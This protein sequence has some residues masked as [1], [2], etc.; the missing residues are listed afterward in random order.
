[1][2]A[3]FEH[4]EAVREFIDRL[5]L[6]RSSHPR[7]RPPPV[8][9]PA[10]EY[11]PQPDDAAA[12]APVLPDPNQIAAPVPAQLPPVLAAGSY[13]VTG[14][15]NRTQGLDQD[16]GTPTS[17]ERSSR[18]RKSSA[19][20]T[21]PVKGRKEVTC[22]EWCDTMERYLRLN[23]VPE[24][25]QVTFVETYLR[26]GALSLSTLALQQAPP[27]ETGSNVDPLNLRPMIKNWRWLRDWLIS[28]FQPLNTHQSVRDELDV[29]ARRPVSGSV[30]AGFPP[31]V[32]RLPTMSKEERLHHPP[33]TVQGWTY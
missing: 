14:R 25:D 12:A 18:H 3:V 13:Q 5:E 30:P 10:V 23:H 8:V 20:S 2:N 4:E 21:F 1:M 7:P 27:S 24:E 31:L 6:R 33:W 26:G 15:T 29:S 19:G 11:I 17:P 9:G 16:R 22:T 32:R 28:Q